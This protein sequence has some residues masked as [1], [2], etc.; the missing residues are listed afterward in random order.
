MN[1]LAGE[2][3]V[4]RQERPFFLKLHLAYADLAGDKE[5]VASHVRPRDEQRVGLNSPA[6]LRWKQS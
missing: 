4:M 3:K 1:C 2:E 5:H 6:G